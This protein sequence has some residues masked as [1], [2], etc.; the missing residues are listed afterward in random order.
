MVSR[1]VLQHGLI[2]IDVAGQTVECGG[3]EVPVTAREFGVLRALMLHPRWYV[4]A[5]NLASEEGGGGGS[6][7]AVRVHISHLRQKLRDCDCDSSIEINRGLGYRMSPLASGVSNGTNAPFIG[8]TRQVDEIL[9]VMRSVKETG[10]SV[11]FVSGELGAGKSRL[12]EQMANAADA[13]GFCVIKGSCLSGPHS[14]AFL[15]R[16][17]ARNAIETGNIDL[18]AFR[19]GLSADQ[20]RCLEIVESGET[21]PD[22]DSFSEHLFALAGALLRATSRVAPVLF[23]LDNFHEV[24]AASLSALDRLIVRL[25]H[26][27]V[28]ILATYDDIDADRPELR[29]V[30]TRLFMHGVARTVRLGPLSLD[31][32]ASFVEHVCRANLT[33]ESVEEVWSLS[34]GNP[35]AAQLLLREGSRDT[36][37]RRFRGAWHEIPLSDDQRALVVGRTKGVSDRCLSLLA[38]ASVAGVSFPLTVLDALRPPNCR[39][40]ELDEAIGAGLL[41]E[42]DGSSLNLRFKQPLLQRHL[43]E[44]LAA[45]DRAALHGQA[46]E[47]LLQR[48]GHPDESQVAWHFR[49][50]APAGWV[51]AAF[52][53]TLRE[54]RE[55]TVARDLVTAREAFAEAR[56]LVA[57]LDEGITARAQ[58]VADLDREL[59]SL[60][61]ARTLARAGLL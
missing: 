21:V 45:S 1:Q 19:L 13:E 50:A 28:V 22:I 30:V 43:Y 40:G 41:E 32:M 25:Q 37:G 47:A 14:D 56:G 20:L 55:A 16:T 61:S 4:S 6:K 35:L 15:W 54:A 58:L 34:A 2:T 24:A 52:E 53:H 8:R 3:R 5:E 59:A 57:L 7:P 12:C 36:L 42:V 48:L 10:L 23:V 29:D 27:P 60:D 18:G 9:G 11:V 44:T 33:P 39:N 26:D 38:A 31:E 17:T 51:E 49:K 46:A